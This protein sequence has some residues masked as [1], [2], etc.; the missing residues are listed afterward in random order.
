MNLSDFYTVT[1]NVEKHNRPEV[2]NLLSLGNKTVRGEVVC[3][4]YKF[5]ES[6][7]IPTYKHFDPKSTCNIYRPVDGEFKQL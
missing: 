1:T 5:Y 3:K 2:D 7:Y 6:N 4:T